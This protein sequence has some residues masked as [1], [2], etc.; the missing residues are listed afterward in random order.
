MAHGAADVNGSPLAF[1]RVAIPSDTAC[2]WRDVKTLVLRQ[3]PV[4]R[5]R[6]VITRLPGPGG[7]SH[8]LSH[9]TKPPPRNRRAISWGPGASRMALP[10]VSSAI[11][12][13]GPGGQERTS[14]A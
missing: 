5:K 7:G 3:A 12:P 2:L 10:F 8:P 14:L 1:L 9:P 6:A 4:F 11:H 13:A